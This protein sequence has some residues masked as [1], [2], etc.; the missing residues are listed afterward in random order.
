MTSDMDEHEVVKAA[1]ENQSFLSQTL[2]WVAAGIAGV[3]A[4]LWTNTMGRIA[5]IEKN[6]L[7]KTTFDATVARHDKDR[8]E[9]RETEL[10][11]FAKVD[12]FNDKLD[13]LKDLILTRIK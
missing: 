4:W 7:D 3:G 10:A 2:A 11:L 5:H 6:K 13:D 1:V 12:K 9:R 8:D